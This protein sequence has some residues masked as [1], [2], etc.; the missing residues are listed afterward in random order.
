MQEH[1][2]IASSHQ[3]QV[4]S[5]PQPPPTI[6]TMFLAFLL[7]LLC[8]SIVFQQAPILLQ[9]QEISFQPIWFMYAGSGASAQRRRNPLVA[10]GWLDD[11]TARQRLAPETS[12]SVSTSPR[13]WGDWE[14]PQNQRYQS[15]LDIYQDR[16]DWKCLMFH[17]WQRQTKI[18]F[19]WLFFFL[20]VFFRMSLT[21]HLVGVT[22]VWASQFLS[23]FG[24]KSQFFFRFLEQIQTPEGAHLL[25][26]VGVKRTFKKKMQ[27]EIA[28][29]IQGGRVADRPVWVVGWTTNYVQSSLYISIDIL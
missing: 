21:I 29:E 24:K 4:D 6:Q 18:E 16:S 8:S 7:F 10:A 5:T 1:W 11:Y 17:F 19:F 27:E 13:Q 20:P 25:C 12:W 2:G 14:T 26:P 15:C 3:S 28:I 23:S 22:R 9:Q